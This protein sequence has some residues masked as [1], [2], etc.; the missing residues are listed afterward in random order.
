MRFAAVD[1]DH[2]EPTDHD[3]SAA[4]SDDDHDHIVN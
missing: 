2:F 4:A 1:H 3:Y